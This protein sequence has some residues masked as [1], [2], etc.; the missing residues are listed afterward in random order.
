[1]WWCQGMWY[2][3]RENQST[4]LQQPTSKNP[5]LCTIQSPFYQ[6]HLRISRNHDSSSQ[7]LRHPN[8]R[9]QNQNRNHSQ[10]THSISCK[11]QQRMNHKSQ[12]PAVR[13][14]ERKGSQ[15][16]RTKGPQPPRDSRTKPSTER[17]EFAWQRLQGTWLQT[18]KP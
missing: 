11:N 9:I 4:K 12:Q 8:T 17:H 13:Q 15:R 5:G 6:D 2:L 3:S 18:T 1:M 7:R 14:A 10:S 16:V